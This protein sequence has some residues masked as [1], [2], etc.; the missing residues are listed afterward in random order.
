[1]QLHV[2]DLTTD[3]GCVSAAGYLDAAGGSALG[4]AAR[5]LTAAGHCALVFDL[6]RVHPVSCSGLRA[7]LQL[8]HE[9]QQ[10]RV[11]TVLCGLRPTLE[12]GVRLLAG[13][14]GLPPTCADLDAALEEVR[15]RA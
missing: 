11:R 5:R 1:M 10:L 14:R 3:I 13:G 7:V 2:R 6:T 8:V 15:G 4:E 12:T 9:L